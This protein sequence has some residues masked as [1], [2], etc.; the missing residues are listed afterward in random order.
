MLSACETDVRVGGGYR[1][2]FEGADGASAAFFGRYLEVVEPARLVWTNEEAEDA[3]VTTVTFAAMGDG[4]R[5]VLSER[6]ASP[7]PLEAAIAG[8][9]AMAGEQ[10]DQLE[11]LLRTPAAEDAG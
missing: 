8:M 9:G 11:A 6:Y 10:F 5:L 3:P 2:V 7:E 4:T 1:L